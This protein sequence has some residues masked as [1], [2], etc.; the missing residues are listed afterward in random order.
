MNTLLTDLQEANASFRCGTCPGGPEEGC[1]D[2]CEKHRLEYMAEELG[3]KGWVNPVRCKD[4]TIKTP[5]EF[6]RAWCPLAD[7]RVDAESYCPR[8]TKDEAKKVQCGYC[9]Y[10][11]PASVAIPN[12]VDAL[13]EEY[14]YLCESCY[15]D[16][17]A[18]K[19]QD[20]PKEALDGPDV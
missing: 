20:E 16:L 10:E 2:Q 14:D 7:R 19:L 13:G 8:G 1:D 4:C 17:G 11:V 5:N 9:N 12:C 15:N 18:E 6:G 3:K